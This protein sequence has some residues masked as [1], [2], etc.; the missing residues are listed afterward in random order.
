MLAIALV[1]P[2]CRS[3]QSEAPRTLPPVAREVIAQASQTRLA[4]VVTG[5]RSVD[6]IS[7]AGLEGLTSVLAI[8]TA[9]EP[10]PPVAVD[11]ARDELALHPFL[12]WPIVANRPLPSPKRCASSIHT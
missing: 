9:L 11:P 1:L 10:G 4:Y 5:E 7:R 12:Y 3:A 8:R 2:E 6:E